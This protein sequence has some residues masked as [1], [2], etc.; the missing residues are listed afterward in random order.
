[1]AGGF[2]PGALEA[3]DA[4]AVRAH[5]VTCREPHEEIA[6]LGSVVPA[7]VEIVPLVEPPADLKARIMA[8]AAADAAA[9][10][11]RGRAAHAEPSG[12]PAGVRPDEAGPTGAPATA[13][14]AA[15]PVR[16]PISRMG[17][18][19]V[20]TTTGTWALRIAAVLAISALGGWNL[21]LQTQL[22]EARQSDRNL[23]A[24]L[25]TAVQPGSLTAVLAGDGGAGSGLAAVDAA[26]HVAIAL[27]DLAPTT[28]SAVYEAWVIGRARVV[29]IASQRASDLASYA[30]SVRRLRAL[31]S[32]PRLLRR[33]LDPGLLRERVR[34]P[35][36]RPR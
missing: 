3:A 17:P 20:P 30:L 22:N 7:F 16:F 27:H 21:L 8:A 31:S 18:R 5:L 10:T 6:K 24:I 28:A 25:D 14:P 11:P 36:T 33:R 35:R 23:A 4:A 12:R 19:R 1:M 29:G 26:G 34:A 13:S 2:V 15:P 9:V 32:L